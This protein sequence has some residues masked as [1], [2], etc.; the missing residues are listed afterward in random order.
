VVNTGLK[1]LQSRAQ[2]GEALIRSS[3]YTATSPQEGSWISGVTLFTI[4][5]ICAILSYSHQSTSAHTVKIS[6]C[7]L[8]SAKSAGELP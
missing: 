8:R 1:C 5:C 2:W 7:L 6:H 3:T 4:A